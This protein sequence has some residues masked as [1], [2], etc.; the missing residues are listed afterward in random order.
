[1]FMY[2]DPFNRATLSD[3]KYKLLLNDPEEFW[4]IFEKKP[5][6]EFKDLV[7]KMLLRKV[8]ERITID[9]IK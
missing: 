5:S 9:G 3:I 8:S 7:R 4:K 1:M 6:A 2:T